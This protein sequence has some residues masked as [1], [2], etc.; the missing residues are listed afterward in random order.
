LRDFWDNFGT[1]QLKV[2]YSYGNLESLEIHLDNA[3]N[4]MDDLRQATSVCKQIKKLHVVIGGDG[5][6]RRQTMSI[7]FKLPNLE[8]IR[9]SQGD[10]YKD[11]YVYKAWY[12]ADDP[13]QY[14]DT[15]EEDG[16]EME[17]QIQVKDLDW[18]YRIIDSSPK[19]R[20]L[21]ISLERDRFDRD[22]PRECYQNILAKLGHDGRKILELDWRQGCDMVEHNLPD[23][24]S[25]DWADLVKLPA[26]ELLVT[27]WPKEDSYVACRQLFK[28][29]YRMLTS[30]CMC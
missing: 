24:F 11:G 18:F 25:D 17:G 15:P 28:A 22:W 9:L 12:A 10:G 19:L 14:E 23:I 21:T 29:S 6:V 20:R 2:L 26:L 27:Q 5:P 1:K 8:E 7:R 3:Y 16:F 30:L 4:C 13:Y